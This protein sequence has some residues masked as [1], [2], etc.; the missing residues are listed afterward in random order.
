MTDSVLNLIQAKTKTG[1]VLNH[2][3]ENKENDYAQ[4]IREA[5]LEV[6]S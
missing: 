3:E 5:E 2:I 1:G 6:H 4:L